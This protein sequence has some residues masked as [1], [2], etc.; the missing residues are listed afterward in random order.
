[1]NFIKYDF[2]LYYSILGIAASVYFWWR[3]NKIRSE[4]DSRRNKFEKDSI[5]NSQY[6]EDLKKVNENSKYLFIWLVI[7]SV[8]SYIVYKFLSFKI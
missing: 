1:M 6:Y 7:L 8:I 4:A 3:E 2:V 5:G